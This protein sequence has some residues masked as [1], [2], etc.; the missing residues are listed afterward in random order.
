MPAQPPNP[1]GRAGQGAITANTL[2]NTQRFART[3]AARRPT[4]AQRGKPRVPGA[5]PPPPRETPAYRSRPGSSTA[6]IVIALFAAALIVALIA[7]GV[8][9]AIAVIHSRHLI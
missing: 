7:A 6:E 3:L 2:A 4:G 5:V 8:V 1:A 9:V